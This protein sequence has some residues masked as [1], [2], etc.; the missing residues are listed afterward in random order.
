MRQINTEKHLTKHSFISVFTRVDRKV[1]ATVQQ[2]P[3]SAPGGAIKLWLSNLVEQD[4][5]KGLPHECIR[6]LYN[7]YVVFSFFS[8]HIQSRA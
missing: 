2:E 4:D 7:E 1:K 8:F 5:L 3:L 6:P